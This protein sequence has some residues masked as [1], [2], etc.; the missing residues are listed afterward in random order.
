MNSKWIKDLNV[1]IKKKVL[2]KPW[3]SWNFR[4]EK[5]ILTEN[6]KAIKDWYIQLYKNNF[7]IEEKKN[8][9]QIKIVNSQ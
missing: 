2:D 5:A 8:K 1:Y 4:I 7:L 3:E 9:T 6:Q